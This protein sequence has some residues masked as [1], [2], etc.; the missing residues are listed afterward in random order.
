MHVGCTV[1]FENRKMI[2]QVVKWRIDRISKV[3]SI[4]LCF[5]SYINDVRIFFFKKRYECL[6][7]DGYRSVIANSILK[8]KGIHN[9]IDVLGGFGAIRKTGVETIDF[10]CPSTKK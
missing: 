4:E 6:G 5:F 2:I 1:F 3:L 8:A 7:S 10:V 9:V